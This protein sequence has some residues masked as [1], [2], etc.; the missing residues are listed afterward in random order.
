MKEPDWANESV[1]AGSLTII[2]SIGTAYK[3][4]M[5]VANW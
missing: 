1:T 5:T 4:D 3:T 2:V